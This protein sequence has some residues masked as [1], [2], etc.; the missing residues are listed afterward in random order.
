MHSKPNFFA[1]CWP[2]AVVFFFQ[3]FS[4]AQNPIGLPVPCRKGKLWGLADPSDGRIIL[5]PTLDSV[6]RFQKY[7]SPTPF[8]WAKKDGLFGL[9][10]RKGETV[11]PFKEVAALNMWRSLAGF[12]QVERL[13]FGAK[14]AD[15]EAQKAGESY[16]GFRPIAFFDTTGE[17]I[18]RP[19]EFENF[20]SFEGADGSEGYDSCDPS[21]LGENTRGFYWENQ[22]VQQVW[23]KGK[24]G[25][26]DLK[27]G[28][29]IASP[30]WKSIEPFGQ[31]LSLG[32][33]GDGTRY[34]PKP[35]DELFIIDLQND[36]ERPIPFPKTLEPNRDFTFSET[37]FLAKDRATGLFG[38]LDRKYEVA[39]PF[40]FKEARP[41]SRAGL[42]VARRAL[43]H[44]QNGRVR[45]ARTWPQPGSFARRGWCFLDKIGRRRAFQ[46]GWSNGK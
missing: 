14:T 37:R 36:P 32:R 16:F 18:G 34:D 7:N 3:H 30:R 20:V 25:L 6:G 13:A 45:F 38:Y 44:H 24:V 5:T 22:T 42:A 29:I 39:I 8:V 27:K 1:R 19:F 41:F 33:L 40:I 35:E 21:G 15:E 12:W 28:R 2:F 17:V 46:E 43:A 4:F 9:L 23:K 11:L 26:F 10:N 31:N